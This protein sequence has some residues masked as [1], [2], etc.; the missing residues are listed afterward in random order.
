MVEVVVVNNE[1]QRLKSL[2]D[3]LDTHLHVEHGVRVIY[4]FFGQK[5]FRRSIFTVLD[6]MRVDEYDLHHG[7]GRLIILPIQIM[8]AYDTDIYL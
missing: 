1:N 7:I 4:E 5:I 8:S 3:R 2:H 6:L